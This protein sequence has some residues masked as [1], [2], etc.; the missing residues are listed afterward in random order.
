MERI[1]KKIQDLSPEIFVGTSGTILAFGEMIAQNR[2][3]KSP[4]TISIN[5]VEGINQKLQKTTVE[6]RLKFPGLDKKRVDQIIGGGV[7]LESVLEKCRAN[8]LILCDRA[9]REGLIADFLIRK[10]PSEP[11]KV[12]AR[13]LRSKSVLN[14]LNRW[15][16]D[17]RHMEH[18]ARLSLQLFDALSEFHRRGIAEREILEYAS[19]LHDVGRVISYPGHHKHGWY[20]IKNANLIGFQPAEIDMIA[21]IVAYHRK[22][23]PR[24]KD[25]YLQYLRRRDRRTV[26][27]LSSV[28]RIA[29]ALDRQ[30]NQ[31]ITQIKATLEGPGHLS[32]SLYSEKPALIPLRAAIERSALLQK[33]LKLKQI[34][35]RVESSQTAAR[36]TAS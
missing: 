17:R 20:I 3:E 8:E 29:D 14:L 34:D 2:K 19:L 30:H 12:Q 7:L 25:H 6:E 16:I 28:V 26:A 36:A 10:T 24:K 33:A 9:L 4:T 11:A 31:A 27:L 21:A 1:S 5:E 35:F 18:S 15:D 13:E 22:K 23:K 32:I